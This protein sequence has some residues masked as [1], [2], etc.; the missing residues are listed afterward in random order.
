VN[1]FERPPENMSNQNPAIPGIVVIGAGS[2]SVQR[3][4]PVAGVARKPSKIIYKGEGI[5]R[6]FGIEN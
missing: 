3:N 1:I 6:S 2:A 5:Y 4:G